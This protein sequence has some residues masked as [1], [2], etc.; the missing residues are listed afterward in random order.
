VYRPK[1]SGD[2]DWSCARRPSGRCSDR[3]ASS[4]SPTLCLD[5]PCRGP[6]SVG[7]HAP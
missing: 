3:I 1:E 4:S 6:P 2:P 5:V 7:G